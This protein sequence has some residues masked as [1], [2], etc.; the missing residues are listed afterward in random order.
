[1]LI[2]ECIYLRTGTIRQDRTSRTGK[3][4][5]CRRHGSSS[6]S[7]PLRDTSHK[8]MS[9]SCMAV[10]QWI[11]WVLLH[12]HCNSSGN[13]VDIDPC[14]YHVELNNIHHNLCI[15]PLSRLYLLCKNYHK[16]SNPPD[17]VYCKEFFRLCKLYHIEKVLLGRNCCKECFR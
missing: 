13:R 14:I 16:Q 1:M 9:G 3:T 10:V 4:S 2:S 7:I 17:K 8:R 12:D 5:R 11:F 6:N 15:Y